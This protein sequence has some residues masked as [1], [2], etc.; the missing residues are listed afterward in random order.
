MV[1]TWRRR[2]RRPEAEEML[3]I[4]RRKAPRLNHLAHSVARLAVRRRVVGL[5]ISTPSRDVFRRRQ[6]LC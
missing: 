4:G 2:S 3:S 5:S 1:V 6:L